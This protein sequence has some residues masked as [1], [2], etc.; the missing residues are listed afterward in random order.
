M[1]PG[2]ALA[3]IAAVGLMLVTSKAM[4]W[5]S[6]WVGLDEAFVF[7][8]SLLRL[9]VAFL[10]LSLV[11]SIVYRF[12]PNAAASFR[13]VVPGGSPSY[14]VLRLASL[15]FAFVLTLFS[16]IRRG[17]WEPRCGHLAT[18]LPLPP[19]GGSAAGSGSQRG[20]ATRT[21]EEGEAYFEHV[22]EPTPENRASRRAVREAPRDRPRIAV[23][24]RSSPKQAFL[25]TTYGPSQLPR[26]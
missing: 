8:W 22:D 17:L 26:S 25:N 9:P 15:A 13:S 5:L 14:N 6:W 20:D 19:G 21:F 1:A 23:R 10:L 4:A 24:M 16:A 2:L 3:V 12:A 7:L 11:V 18:P